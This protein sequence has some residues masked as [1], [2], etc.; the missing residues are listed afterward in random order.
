M[1]SEKDKWINEILDSGAELKMLKA[2]GGLLDAINHALQE[3]QEEKLIPF[4]QL[5]LPMI[6]AAALIIINVAILFS[7]DGWVEPKKPEAY[8]IESYN[9]NIY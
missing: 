6:A 3:R 1:E 2:P 5:R 9:L 4:S 8:K 7:A